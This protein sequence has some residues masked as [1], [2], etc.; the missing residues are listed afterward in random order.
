MYINIEIYFYTLSVIDNLINLDSY[1]FMVRLFLKIST[2]SA[3]SSTATRKQHRVSVSYNKKQL[4]LP[5]LHMLKLQLKS[6]KIQLK[7]IIIDIY[8]QQKNK[9]KKKT[10]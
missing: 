4:W 6:K 2:Y 9:N 3:R 8:K 7:I 10:P 1:I 5:E